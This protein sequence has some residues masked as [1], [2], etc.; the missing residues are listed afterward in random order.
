M[1]FAKVRACEKSAHHY[2][3]TAAF[4]PNNFNPINN[5]FS[6]RQISPHFCRAKRRNF[7]YKANLQCAKIFFCDFK[8]NAR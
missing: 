3:F 1:D 6:L 7:N 4:Y 5:N 2:L 8:F